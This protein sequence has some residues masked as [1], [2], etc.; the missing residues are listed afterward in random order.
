MCGCG[1]IAASEKEKGRHRRPPS[2]FIES[3][4]FDQFFDWSTI[5]FFLIHGR[6]DGVSQS[7]ALRRPAQQAHAGA[8]CMMPALKT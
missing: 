7:I 2:F 5:L 3:K 6:L 8:C 1:S 4:K